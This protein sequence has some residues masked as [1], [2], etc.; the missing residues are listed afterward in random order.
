MSCINFLKRQFQPL[1]PIASLV[2]EYLY[3]NVADTNEE[4]KYAMRS[5]KFR[6]VQISYKIVGGK[7]C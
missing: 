2:S 7:N 4:L 5:L 3:V 6:Q 1:E